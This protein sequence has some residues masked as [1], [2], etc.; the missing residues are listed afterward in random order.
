LEDVVRLKHSYRMLLADRVKQDLISAVKATNPTGDVASAIELLEHWDNTAAAESRGSELFEIWWQIYSV[1][2]PIGR[3]ASTGDQQSAVG[4]RYPDEK[5]FARVWSPDDPLNTPRGLADTARAIE[6]FA[7][8][9]EET[10]RRYGG[11]DVTWGDVHRVRRGTVDVPVGGCGND[12]G[13]FRILSFA[14]DE[15]DGKLAA[16]GGDGWVLAV[17][18]DDTPRAYSVLAYGESRLSTSPW[19]AD[20]AEMF[21]KGEVK[22]VAFTKADVDAQAVLRFRPGQNRHE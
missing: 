2:Q 6:S 21:A 17:E 18:F 19:H 9:V 4:T 8:A 3:S 7:W 5:R 20:Q 15:K 22:K 12:L 11:I 13:C 16:N 1:R 10:K 14:R